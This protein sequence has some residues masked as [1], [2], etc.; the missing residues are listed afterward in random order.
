MSLIKHLILIIMVLFF[1]GCAFIHS[2]DN[3]LPQQVE[4]WMQNKEYAKVIDTL[5][6]L[7]ASHPHY[8]KLV[9]LR[10]VAVQKALEYETYILTRGK[11][12]HDKQL[13]QKAYITYEQGLE[14]L[15][16]SAAI[17]QAMN[18]FVV[19]RDAY[20]KQL[21]YEILFNKSQAILANSPIQN[22]ITTAAPDNYRYS[23]M[24]RHHELEKNEITVELLDC[25]EST[26]HANQLITSQKCLELASNLYGDPSPKRLQALQN[27]LK[28][29]RKSLSQLLSQTAQTNLAATADALKNR[30]LKDAY[31]HIQKIPAEEQQKPAVVKLREQLNKEIKLTVK[32]GA[33]TGRKLYS[34]GKI[35]EAL[36]IWQALLLLEPDNLA[37]KNHI[38][39][40]QRVLKKLKSLGG[41]KT[42]A[43]QN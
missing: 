5:A 17:Q 28:K 37:L 32:Q 39:R 20:I 33:A 43:S 35:K 26:L 30:K 24:S 36:E 12:F 21:S 4:D 41:D 9:P 19:Q 1:S 2:L 23:T 14:K 22:K 10:E 3:N 42:P 40:A 16:G 25:A 29:K 15:P 6:Y 38:E 27:K 34:A 31:D 8:R 11:Q 7:R 13:W 18:E